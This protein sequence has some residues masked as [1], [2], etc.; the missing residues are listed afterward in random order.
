MLDF[1]YITPVSIAKVSTVLSILDR[2]RYEN[3]PLVVLCTW[4]NA[5]TRSEIVA[6][7]SNRAPVPNVFSNACYISIIFSMLLFVL[8]I[9]KSIRH[10]SKLPFLVL[11]YEP[12]I[13][14]YKPDD[15]SVF[16]SAEYITYNSGCNYYFSFQRRLAC[17]VRFC[18]VLYFYVT[19]K[20]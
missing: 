8:Q 17:I 13:L 15:E 12:H 9:S 11:K 20:E 14:E 10:F 3:D 2:K 4:G 1:K 7:L 18:R 19:Y 6:N 16:E 5:L